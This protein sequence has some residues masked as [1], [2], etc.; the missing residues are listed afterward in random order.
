V[1]K[2]S[3]RILIMMTLSLQYKDS[4]SQQPFPR[5]HCDVDA[6]SSDRYFACTAVTRLYNHSLTEGFEAMFGEKP[7][8]DEIA[9]LQDAFKRSPRSARVAD[10]MSWYKG[11]GALNADVELEWK[12]KDADGAV[13][14]SGSAPFYALMYQTLD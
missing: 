12:L 13:I 4:Y 14:K 5:V 8:D 10:L 3:Q 9:D 1:N 6:D 2:K 7:N 11:H